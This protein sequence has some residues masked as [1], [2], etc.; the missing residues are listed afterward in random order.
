[1]ARSEA[2][3]LERQGR[4]EPVGTSGKIWR[5]TARLQETPSWESGDGRVSKLVPVS[6]QLFIAGE[7]RRR[8]SWCVTI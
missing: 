7:M 1:M 4:I 6:L 8:P 2:K 3:A 5:W